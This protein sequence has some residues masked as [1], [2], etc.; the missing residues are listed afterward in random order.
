M[1]T[2]GKLLPLRPLAPAPEVTDETLLERCASGDR[3][4]LGALFDRH[5]D[6]VHRFLVRLC[7]R[8]HRDAEDLLQAT[9]LE[10]HRS[11]GSFRGRCSVRTWLLAVSANVARHHARAEGRRRSALEGLSPLADGAGDSPADVAERRQESQR[12]RQVLAGLEER[13]RTPFVLC[14]VQGVPDKEAARALGLPV[15]TL[16]RRI[17]DARQR[18]RRSIEED[19]R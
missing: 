11:A 7:G 18:L 10:A 12:L 19:E 15:G 6:S 17:H 1:T 3:V 9:F 14:V 13:L 16:W 2:M 8:H 5:K 4:A